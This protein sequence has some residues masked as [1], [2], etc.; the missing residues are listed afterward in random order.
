[1][2]AQIEFYANIQGGSTGELINNGAGSGLGFYGNGF[3]ISVPVG[4]QQS[5]TFVTNATGT[6]EGSQLNN[7][8]QADTLEAQNPGRVAINSSTAIDTNKL[9][10][11]MCPLNVRFTNDDAVRVQ[12]CKMRIFDRNSI[13]NNASGVMTYVYEARHP[14]SDQNVSQLQ[15][16]GRTDNNWVEYGEGINMQDMTFTGSPGASG[17]N[18]IGETDPATGFLTNEG[19]LHESTRHD[20]YAALSSEPITIGSK[21]Q[22]A[23]YF[24]CEYLS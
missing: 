12:N 7:T 6:D 1:M 9:P 4:T 24:S 18:S 19:A 11:Y 3:G 10:N 21:T 8:A 23:L 2:A 16:R 15:F 5:T 22:Y 14:S 13:D 17:T 20:W